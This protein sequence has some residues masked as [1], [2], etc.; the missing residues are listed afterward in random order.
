MR[1]GTVLL[2]GFAAAGA[3]LLGAAE[4]RPFTA[5]YN[6]S[7]HGMS[8]GNSQLQLEQL[9]DGTWRYS[10]R[11]R[12]RGIFRIALPSEL[13]Q[14]SLFTLQDDQVQ[15]LRFEADDGS[16]SSSKGDADL[17]FDWNR[18]RVTG[19]S[20]GKD[21]DLP[22]TPGL[23]DAMSIQVSL[24]HALLR[25]GTPQRFS[26]LDGDRVKEYVYTREGSETLATALGSHET[27]IF[28]SARPDSTS[29][30]W[31]WCAPDLGYLPVKVERRD[32]RKVEWS[33]SLLE[34]HVD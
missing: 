29:G 27:V 2:A 17:R 26:M 14:R 1:L 15:P 32:G 33:M 22:L 28:R 5:S 19:R 16:D 18:G 23:Q 21:V 10:S 25:G 11:N 31:F 24:M 8:A 20:G 3:P 13:S 7:W 6:V 12:A 4:L 9:G 30:T 34:A